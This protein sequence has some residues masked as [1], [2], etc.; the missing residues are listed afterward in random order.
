MILWVVLTVLTAV[1]A[2]VLTIPLVRRQ[3]ARADARTATIAV[4]RDQLADVDVQLAAGTIPPADAEGLRVEI[5]RRMLAAGH[6]PDDAPRSLGSRALAGVA[7]GLAA[8]VALAAGALYSSMGKPG[9]GD[10]VGTIA[11]APAA[12]PAAPQASEV[13]GLITALEKRMESTPEDPNGWRMLGWT[14]FQSERFADAATAYGK[15]VALRPDGEG[16][17]SAYGEALTL[18]ANGNVTP[19]AQAAFEAAVKRDGNDARARYFLGQAKLQGGDSKGAIDDWIRL[20][21]DSAADAPWIPQ[22]RS[23]IDGAAR[24]AGIDVTARLAA[25]KQPVSGG[26]SVAAP[27]MAALAGAAASAAGPAVPGSAPGAPAPSAEQVAGAAAM[28]PADRQAM[29]TG[30]VDRLAARLAAN[31]KDEAG[32]LRLI[33][34]RG[35]MGDPAATAKARDDA[36]KA[37]AGDAAATARIKAAAAEAGA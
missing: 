31:P 24:A 27:P 8:L 13:A 9:M 37:F 29:I 12:A 10:S 6:I 34:A 16:Y 33:R 2:A 11:A 22:L 18:A 35:V 28:S 26:A 23:S 19:A 4:L 3:E 21:G 14:Y 17:Q 25:I 15:A 5:K 36:L 30:M 20:L 32:W 7:I 1:A